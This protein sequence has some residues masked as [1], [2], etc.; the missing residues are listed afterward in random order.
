M[1]AIRDRQRQCQLTEFTTFL[2]S[3]N[4]RIGFERTHIDTIDFTKYKLEFLFYTNNSYHFW[5]HCNRL[6]C[7]LIAYH[8]QKR[9]KKNKK[10]IERNQ[11]GFIIIRTKPINEMVLKT[12][13]PYPIQCTKKTISAFDYDMTADCRINE[14]FFVGLNALRFDTLAPCWASPNLPSL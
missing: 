7:G 5:M 14:I 1:T 11:S 12:Q 6:L 2:F 9:L 8:T 4:Y 10:R 3:F 13:S